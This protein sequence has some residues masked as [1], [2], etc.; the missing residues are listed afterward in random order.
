MQDVRDGFQLPAGTL[1][2]RKVVH[3]HELTV[4]AGRARAVLRTNF[5]RDGRAVALTVNAY[6]DLGH[7]N[8]YVIENS[9]IMGRS[10]AKR[11]PSRPSRRR[12]R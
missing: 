1:E 7:H 8:A 11:R 10:A 3:R 9:R 4:H 6:R 5:R 12:G 2:C